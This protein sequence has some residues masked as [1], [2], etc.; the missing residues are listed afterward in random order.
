MSLNTKQRREL[1][2][3]CLRSERLMYARLSPW[4]RFLRWIWK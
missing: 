1:S 4:A 3:Y 2:D